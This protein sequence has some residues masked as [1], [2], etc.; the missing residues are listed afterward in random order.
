MC[1]HNY[2]ALLN[3]IILLSLHY[4]SFAKVCQGL[5]CFSKGNRF[6]LKV[7]MARDDQSFNALRLPNTNKMLEYCFYF[8]IY[9]LQRGVRTSTVL[10]RVIALA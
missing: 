3:A 1:P 7:G 6:G 5:C 9:R 10:V 8:I 4:L 2:Y